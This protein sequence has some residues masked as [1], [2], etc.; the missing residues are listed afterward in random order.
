LLQALARI[1][2][3]INGYVDCVERLGWFG[4]CKLQTIGALQTRLL[5]H[6]HQIIGKLDPDIELTYLAM[7]TRI[8][9]L[10][11]LFKTIK[12]CVGPMGPE[13]MVPILDPL[14]G[15]QSY[16]VARDKV[17][18]GEIE[19]LRAH[20]VFQYAVQ[21]D[22]PLADILSLTRLP[23]LHACR[24]HVVNGVPMD[25]VA[26]QPSNFQARTGDVKDEADDDEEDGNEDDDTSAQKKKP[27]RRRVV[28]DVVLA[29]AL[30][31]REPPKQQLGMMLANAMEV[32]LSK[33][34]KLDRKY[35][36]LE[37]FIDGLVSLS[38]VWHD[39]VEGHCVG[40]SVFLCC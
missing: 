23:G 6:Q 1:R 38:T 2:G 40:E 32:Q 5:N 13:L 16:M 21:H 36:M 29:D 31:M 12:K 7:K 24:D 4:A 34:P 15:L 10:I 30:S 28:C 8:L 17:F 19:I 37:Q 26:K 9:H 14:E 3:A 39:K 35:D 25:A 27:K 33:L 11:R 22:I 20:C 18:A